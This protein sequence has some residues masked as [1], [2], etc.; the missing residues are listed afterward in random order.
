MNDQQLSEPSAQSQLEFIERFQRLLDSGSFVATYK[1]ALLI[2][3][4]NVAAE[5]GFDDTREQKVDIRDLGQQ[6]L[7]LYWTHV[8]EYPGLD[9]PLKQNTGRQAAILATVERAR[10]NVIRPD[11]ADAPESVPERILRE[12][13][14]RVRQMPLMKLQTIGLEKPDPYDPDN[15]LYPT[16]LENGCITLRPGVS[17]CLRRFRG[18][19]VSSTQAAW[20]EY[21]RR[22]NPELGAGHDL[23][24]FLFGA[25]RSTVHP[26]APALLDVQ[27]GRCFYTGRPLTAANAHVDHFIPWA[28][29]PL[30]SPFNLVV[31]S[32]ASNL[33]KSDHLAA[34][35][36]VRRWRERNEHHAR[37]LRE[38]G[39][40]A[41]DDSRTLAV[42]RY[43]Y[44]S[45][46]RVHAL[47]WLHGRVMEELVGCQSILTAA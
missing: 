2:A 13:T 22:H 3:L 42:A 14:D 28:K 16:V 27:E 15:F 11:R 36:H 10:A 44:S 43:V 25:D 35:P 8:R 18:L 21:V 26:L 29:F 47:G 24:R 45:A 19:I 33:H 46:E 7:R 6:F 39:A 31:A 34:L 40:L 32:T 5:K 17:A 12:A 1:Y 9:H 20:S 38:L 4:C 41:E 30:N 23:D 37:E